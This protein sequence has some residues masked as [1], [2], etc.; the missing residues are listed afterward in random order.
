[1]KSTKNVL[2]WVS[3]IK[4]SPSEFALLWQKIGSEIKDKQIAHEFFQSLKLGIRKQ[5][6]N[7]FL[8]KFRANMCLSTIFGLFLPFNFHTF[9]ILGLPMIIINS[10]VS[11]SFC[12]PTFRFWNVLSLYLVRHASTKA[13]SN[14]C[15]SESCTN[16][17][18]VSTIFEFS[19]YQS[20]YVS[21]ALNDGETCNP[22]AKLCCFHDTSATL[23][24]FTSLCDC[25][26]YCL[27]DDLCF[28]LANHHIAIPSSNTRET[29]AS[30]MASMHFI[31]LSCSKNA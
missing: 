22:L 5:E 8:A 19:Y 28:V 12:D 1:M 4:R 30:W 14:I 29:K 13:P 9:C 26:N 25:L 27:H 3:V 7:V 24:I 2:K 31:S 15:C 11:I 6:R 18:N 21:L 23:V 17:I 10:L 16:I 20:R